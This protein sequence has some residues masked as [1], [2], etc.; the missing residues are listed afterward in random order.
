[1]VL[2]NPFFVG[3]VFYVLFSYFI[4]RSTKFY[5]TDINSLIV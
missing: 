5:F 3:D 1:M 2:E 4:I